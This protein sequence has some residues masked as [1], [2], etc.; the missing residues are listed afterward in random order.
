ML[1]TGTR[2]SKDVSRSKVHSAAF[3][4]GSRLNCA[5]PTTRSNTVGRLESEAGADGGS[6]MGV[7]SG[8][9]TRSAVEER[10]FPHFMTW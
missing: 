6:L 4:V 3:W 8:C 10:G 5:G 7:S 1:I 2:I 9:S